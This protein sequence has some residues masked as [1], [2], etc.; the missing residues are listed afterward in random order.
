MAARSPS[1]NSNVVKIISAVVILGAIC[2]GAYFYFQG[3][4][5]TQAPT[6][7]AAKPAATPNAATTAAAPAPAAAQPVPDLTPEQLSKE[8]SAAFR[9]NR[10]IT[11]PG[12]N[13]LEYYLSLLEKQP[14]NATAKDA[15]REMFPIV[16]GAVEQDINSGALDEGS[17]VINLLAKADPNNYTLTILRTKLDARKKVL[18]REEAQKAEAQKAAEAQRT[19]AAAAAA[20]A[21]SAAAANTQNPAAP[22]AAPGADATA[23]PADTAAAKPAAVA[24]AAPAT[25]PAAAPPVVGGETHAAEV[26]KTSAPQ[27]PPDAARKRQEGWVEVEFTV[28]ADGSIT[29]VS[30]VNANPTRVFNDSAIRAVQS[31]TFKPRMDNGKPADEKMRRRIEFRLGG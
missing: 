14:N 28:T 23:K 1:N 21:N 30:V 16:T 22:A 4:S 27:Y 24:T 13:A 7:G 6:V 5:T 2:A 26:V 20:G 18:D 8:A 3:S 19:A 17:R 10:L 25:P 15:L 9:E 31:W 11:P 29:G 12:N